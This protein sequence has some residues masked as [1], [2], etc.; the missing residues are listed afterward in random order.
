MIQLYPLILITKLKKEV[1]CC[2]DYFQHL[3]GNFVIIQH[4]GLAI[5]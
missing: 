4:Q 3:D 5:I 2:A 1:I